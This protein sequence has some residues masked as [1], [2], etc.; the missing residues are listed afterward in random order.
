MEP[1]QLK[2]TIMALAHN[3]AS[4]TLVS[5][6]VLGSTSCET[7]DHILLFHYSYCISVPF[8][9]P[10]TENTASNSSSIVCIFVAV[11]TYLL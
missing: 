5:S 10:C 2:A 9:C 11:G 8:I 1:P 4:V 6:V 7:R 3:S